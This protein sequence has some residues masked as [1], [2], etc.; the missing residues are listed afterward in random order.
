MRRTTV[1]VL[2]L[3]AAL[4]AERVRVRADLPARSDR[5]VSYTIRARLDPALKEIRG[6]MDLVWRNASSG[7]VDEIYFHLYLNAFRDKDSTYMREGNEDGKAGSRWDDEH[8]G[9]VRIDKLRGADGADLALT[10]VQ[11]DDFNEKDAT[12]ARLKLP[13]P[14]PPQETLSLKLDFTSRLPRVLARTGWSGD[15]EDPS[16]LSFMA[17]Q[18]FPKVAALRQ[19]EKGEPRWNAHQFHRNTEFF[20]DYGTYLVSLTVPDGYKV[21]ATGSPSDPA[22]NADGTVTTTFQQ[23][24]VHD[25]A[26]TASPRYRVKEFAWT[27]DGFCDDSAKLGLKLRELLARTAEH[28][29]LDPSQVKPLTAVNVRIL[30]QEDHED[31]VPRIYGAAGAA[32]ACCGMWFGAYPYPT[33]TIVDPPAGG[34]AAGGMEYPTLITIFSD[35]HAPDYATGLETVTMHEFGHEFFYGLLGSN[36]FEESWLDEGFTSFVDSRVHEVALGP[37]TAA[38][39]YG[40]VYVPFF[41]P[42]EAP[43]IYGRLRA[44][45]RFDKLIDGLPR[46]WKRP[47]SLF[48]VPEGNVFWDYLRDMPALHFDARVRIVQPLGDR[49]GYLR[50]NTRDAMVLKGWE[51][52]NRTDYRANSYPKPALLLYT[53][54]GL[55]GDAAFD[56]MMYAYAEKF[57]FGH[58]RTE[59]FLAVAKAQDASVDRFLEAMVETAERF[60]AAILDVSQ[61]KVEVVGEALGQPM[62]QGRR[63]GGGEKWEWTIKVQRRGAI[64]LPIEVWANGELLDT[65][66]SR[67]RETSRTF[68]VLRDGPLESA[69]LGPSWLQGIDADVSNNARSVEADGVPAA[70]LAA[71]WTFYVEDLVRSCAGVAR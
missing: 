54:R 15:P 25:F 59:D 36:E 71:R 14:V 37:E 4:V 35:A 30:Y 7:P 51:F 19:D 47:E 64:E 34:P 45:L 24:D 28:R 29:G 60:D 11:P 33:L 21:G 55:M 38:T 49:N 9:F 40:P 27:F 42:F 62:T 3:F 20:A 32:L 22:R 6:E 63:A 1:L 69:R 58:P 8:P 31:L 57:R 12:L 10:F 16:S 2:V 68:R 56:R 46:P 52:A 53:L 18:W 67:G 13:A 5:V 61:R 17:A 26:W 66:M 39:R 43:S 23:D 70:T 44:L 65:W 41:R 50:S 48:P